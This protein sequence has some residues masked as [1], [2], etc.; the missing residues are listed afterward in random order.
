MK[1]L[2]PTTLMNPHWSMYSD[3][4]PNILDLWRAGQKLRAVWM[5]RD[6][7]P[8]DWSIAEIHHEILRLN[9]CALEGSPEF[10]KVMS[11]E[12]DA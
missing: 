6:Y 2:T 4:I 9:A 12:R 7:C 10:A 3:V 11:G 5:A 8:G 1:H